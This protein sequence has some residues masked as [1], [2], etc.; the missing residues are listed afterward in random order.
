[1][2][3]MCGICFVRARDEPYLRGGHCDAL[4]LLYFGYLPVV[5]QPLKLGVH[6]I[7][8]LSIIY[9]NSTTG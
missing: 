9:V 3:N 2:Y 7:F 8:C 6:F 4:R 1:M 5:A